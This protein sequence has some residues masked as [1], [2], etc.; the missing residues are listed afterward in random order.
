MATNLGLNGRLKLTVI[1]LLMA[2]VFSTTIYAERKATSVEAPDI[3]EVKAN[4]KHYVGSLKALLQK[5][6]SEDGPI[7]ALDVCGVEGARIGGEITRNTGWSVRRVT[8]R[9]RN[10]LS[11]PDE[12]EAKMLNQFKTKVAEQPD[13]TSLVKY[14]V[15]EENGATYARFMKG[16]R[17][18]AV[19]L[20]CHGDKATMGE[21]GDKIDSLYP[22]DKARDYKLGDLRGAL[23]IKIKLK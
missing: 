19:C 17:V 7:G 21:V 22:H 12:Y 13:T 16:I 23:S 2:C 5:K 3:A 6:M 18:E 11:M 1:M 9:A 10:P 15:V 8:N 4:A 20:T 14:E